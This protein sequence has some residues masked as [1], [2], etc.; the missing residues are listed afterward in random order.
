MQIFHITL[1]HGTIIPTGIRNKSLVTCTAQ[2]A[3]GFLLKLLKYVEVML[4]FFGFS[5]V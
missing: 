5:D 4:S 3:G 2:L 1:N